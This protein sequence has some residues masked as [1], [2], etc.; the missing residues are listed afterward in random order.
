M[1][2]P[3]CRRLLNGLLEHLRRRA[4]GCKTACWNTDWGSRFFAGPG[5][6]APVV[7]RTRVNTVGDWS[8]LLQYGMPVWY[9]ERNK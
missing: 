9:D 8:R 5:K 4:G 1:V 3:P 7:V 6:A 2:T